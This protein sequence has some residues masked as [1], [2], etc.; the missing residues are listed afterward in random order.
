[1]YRHNLIIT[2]PP[3]YPTAGSASATVR[4]YVSKAGAAS[5][6]TDIAK[7]TILDLNNKLVSYSAA[8]KKGVRSVFSQWSSTFV[9]ESGGKVGRSRFIGVVSETDNQL[10][11][12]D[13]HS[14]TA[15]LDI[16]YR[17]N[18]YTLAISLARSSGLGDSGAADIHRRYG[19]YLYTKGDFD[20]AMNQFVKTLG[21]L[22]P[23]YVIRKVCCRPAITLL[24]D[25]TSML[26]AYIISR[27]IS[28]NCT[29]NPSPIP[30]IRL[31]F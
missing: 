13:E 22:Q 6:D 17:R 15:K 28:K 21:S 16:L 23:S 14:T 5:G 1:M 11:R 7:V 29:Q 31:F 26:N 2:S 9:L 20:G 4:N 3:F 12:L 25:S 18:L 24:T 27:R 19:D 10:S 30:I 8:F